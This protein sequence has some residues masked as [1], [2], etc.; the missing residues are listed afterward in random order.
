MSDFALIL[1]IKNRRDFTKRWLEYM[2]QIKFKHKIVIGNG[3]K[4]NDFF[5]KKILNQKSY[6]N[7]NIEYH[8]YNSQTYKDY[9]FMMYDIVKK[10]K[11][12]KFI[13]FCDND[14][15]I[16]PNELDSLINNSKKNKNYISVGD[17][18][19]W[20]KLVGSKLY[21][22]KMCFWSKP[23]Y[24]FLENFTIRYIKN[25][26]INF[27]E[28]FYNIYKKKYLLRTLKEIHEINFSD[29]EIRDFYMKLRIMSFGKT[30]F[31]NTISYLRQHGVSETSSNFSYIENFISKNISEDLSLLKKNIS[32]KIKIKNIINEKISK[33]IHSGY[34][35]YL[36][37][38]VAHNLRQFSLKN[39]F[40]FKKIL[41]EKY[42][43]IFCLV[44]NIINYKS[45][46]SI[47]KNYFGNYRSFKAEL[48]F[49]KLFLQTHKSD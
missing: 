23:L 38:V 7:L 48:N 19:S 35:L 45:N 1:L 43:S 24:R 8:L 11:K 30:K 10:Q 9:Y 22:S 40:L 39:F 33:T 36:Q 2:S 46:L 49:V 21:G 47:K 16:L 17:R 34:K 31:Y 44:K 12:S 29:L 26:F 25:I 42:P 13:K 4:K 5:V 37:N 18:V 20:F 27:Q 15:F 41:E 32:R 28:S 14:D 6:S 3:N